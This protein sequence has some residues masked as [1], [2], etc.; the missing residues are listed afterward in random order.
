MKVIN[1]GDGRKG[2]DGFIHLD[3]KRT[4]NIP[5][6]FE[7]MEKLPFEDESIDH[8]LSIHCVEHL[9][10]ETNRNLMKEVHRVLKPGGVFRI[11]CPDYDI[12]FDLFNKGDV[13]KFQ[14]FKN[15]KKPAFFGRRVGEYLVNVGVSYNLT[16]PSGR[17]RKGFVKN[18]K[19]DEIIKNKF[20][21]FKTQESKENFI[22]W[23]KKF[24]PDKKV[25]LSLIHI[26]GFN[27][28][29]LKYFLEEAGF[30]DVKKMDFKE[31][32]IEGLSKLDKFPKRSMF[33]EGR[34]E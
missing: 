19:F 27:F 28:P 10:D 29:R 2:T 24:I 21:G 13:E 22:Q 8:A 5:I 9:T 25:V 33:V 23:M 17:L 6:D 26:N 12:F 14:D 7:T 20:E 18:S 4:S 30:S 11:S 34:K 1:L 3:K 31:S 15:G 32:Q 16:S